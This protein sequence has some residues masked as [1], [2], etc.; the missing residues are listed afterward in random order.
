MLLDRCVPGF[1]V[2][3]PLIKFYRGRK[4]HRWKFLG[5]SSFYKQFFLLVGKLNQEHW[6]RGAQTPGD[7][8]GF[9]F[10]L[11]P[12]I[13]S[14]NVAFLFLVYKNVYHFARTEKEAPDD[15]FSGH[16][17]IVCPQYEILWNS[18]LWRLEFEVNPRFLEKFVDLYFK[19]LRFLGAFARKAPVRWGAC[20]FWNFYAAYNLK[21]V[22]I[23]FALRRKPEIMQRLLAA[24]CLSACTSSAPTGR[25]FMKFRI[26][27]F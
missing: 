8:G 23:S 10:A 9:F 2:P 22:Q 27:E 19:S 16:Y 21:R 1:G 26:W 11:A 5:G 17:M 7:L 12:I 6:V 13:F 3:R 25:I 24:W 20:S 15:S 14:I 18:V 4:W